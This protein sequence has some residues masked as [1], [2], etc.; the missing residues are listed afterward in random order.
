MQVNTL[1]TV[2]VV[3]KLSLIFLCSQA[4]DESQCIFEGCHCILRNHHDTSYDVKCFYDI[5]NTK[6]R[7]F[8][9]RH[10]HSK[11]FS[12]DINIMLINRY[13]FQ[14]IPDFVFQNLNIQTLILAEND[15][16]S[17]NRHAFTGI[18]GLK[19]LR[20][21]E[22]KLHRVE[23]GVFEPL[24]D[25]LNE[26]G[27]VDLYNID[28]NQLDEL[29]REMLVLEKLN[30][31]K[32]SNMKFSI[33]KE[34]WMAILGNL[35]YLSLASNNLT[36]LSTDL[37]QF[38]SSIISL[39]LND[40]RLSDL[41]TLF[42]SLVPIE[43]ILKELKLSGNQ[44][45]NLLDFPEFQSLEF[46][47]LSKNKLTSLTSITFKSLTKL[48]YLH[49]ASNR[50]KQLDVNVFSNLE[51][52]QVLILSNNELEKVPNIMSLNKLQVL[53]LSNQTGKLTR[54]DDYAF[55]RVKNQ[56][57]S[58]S[59]DLESNELSVFGDRSFCSRYA[60]KSQI[61]E[62]TLSY[63]SVRNL[64]KCV[65]NQLSTTFMP[66]VSLNVAQSEQ[67]AQIDNSDICNCRLKAYALSFGIELAGVCAKVNEA[68]CFSP[69]NTLTRHAKE[70]FL[71]DKK[72]KCNDVY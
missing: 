2:L 55:E 8:P 49:L 68:V 43:M 57:N 5:K 16:E 72:F 66:R 40:N 39:D 4:V 26:L 31:F 38:S 47:D 36:N 11:N 70:E 9:V 28:M 1:S 25:K 62:L 10:I 14:T 59:I 30:T 18:R 48:N 21:I 15:L 60:N 64:N 42:V 33:F 22:K 52:L 29:F 13:K 17:L 24:S 6:Q 45:S 65:W 3:F 37:F 71:C 50:L 53:D 20:I 69:P 67:D 34:E 63:N 35:S 19:M 56:T 23:A 12:N 41:T 51:N 32:L 27:L 44:I 46:L 58:L 54:I 61:H 7:S